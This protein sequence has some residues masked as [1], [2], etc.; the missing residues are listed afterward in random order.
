MNEEPLNK[1]DDVPSKIWTEHDAT[2]GTLFHIP[3]VT[4]H[5]KVGVLASGNLIAQHGQPVV[6]IPLVYLLRD[7]CVDLFTGELVAWF[8]SAANRSSCCTAGP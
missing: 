4:Q 6:N 5:S 8:T 7:Q 2:R 3:V 1:K